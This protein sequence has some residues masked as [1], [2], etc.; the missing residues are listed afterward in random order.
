MESNS[1]CNHTSDNDK[2]LYDIP[3]FISGTFVKYTQISFVCFNIN[4]DFQ[5]LGHISLGQCN[6][7]W[8]KIVFGILKI[9]CYLQ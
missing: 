1:F 7:N 4:Y 2:N 5:N 9:I 3:N 8:F 6:K